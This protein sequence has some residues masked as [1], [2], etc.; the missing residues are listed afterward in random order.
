[1]TAKTHP[2][3]GLLRELAKHKYLYALTLPGILFYLVF[4]YLPIFGIVIAFQDFNPIKGIFGSSFVGLKN[5]RFLLYSNEAFRV[6]LNT[7][8]LNAL[9]IVTGLFMQIATSILIAEIGGKLFKKVA[10]SMLLLPHFLSW[11]IISTFSLALFSTDEGF[12]NYALSL[13]GISPINFYQDASVWPAL[14]VLLK[15]WKATGFGTV[16]YLAAIASIDQE[17]Y[18]AAKIDGASRLQ[19]VFSI[20][21]PLLKNTTFVLLIISVGGIFYGDFGMIYALVGDNPMLRSTTDVIDTYVYRALRINND[22]GSSSAVGLF[23]SV[24]GFIMVLATNSLVK[25]YQKDAA[26]F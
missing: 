3:P 9:F 11:V 10:Q 18:E 4:A 6:V 7:L 14:L 15:I 2:K 1:M 17:I 5:F 22:M 19:A 24:L 16:I 8:F 12:I 25:K 13:L 20:T 26:L 23:Q 21:L